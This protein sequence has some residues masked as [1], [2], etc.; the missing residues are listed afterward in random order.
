MEKIQPLTT[1][2]P[3]FWSARA[4]MEVLDYKSWSSFLHVI[5]QSVKTM[6]TADIPY[7]ENVIQTTKQDN[8]KVLDFKLSRFACFIIVMLSDYKK[9]A[10][11]E[12]QARFLLKASSIG[13]SK[14]D[15]Y[16]LER[17]KIRE[18]IADANKWL[19]SVIARRK[20]QDF[21]AFNE[22]GYQGLYNMSSNQLH[23]VKNVTD[24]KSVQDAMGSLELAVHLL[25]IIL[26]EETIWRKKITEQNPL[27][28]SHFMISRDLRKLVKKHL[29]LE[30]EA[31]PVYE[32]LPNVK[33]KLNRNYKKMN[34]K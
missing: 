7:Y 8:S 19:N 17:F 15:L 11:K 3:Y 24:T 10:V 32:D 34:K 2:K 27:E 14:K 12:A 20:I 1:K 25:R 30:M 18:E 4:L 29:G 23:K 22:S 26:T 31:L 16:Q 13:W 33:T 28:Q 6:I 9:E 5:D 21:S